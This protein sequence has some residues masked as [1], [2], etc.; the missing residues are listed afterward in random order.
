MS[1]SHLVWFVT[2]GAGALSLC[3]LSAVV[4]LGLVGAVGGQHPRWPRFLTTTLHRNLALLS[5][6]SLG[7]HIVTAVLDPFTALGW[8]AALVPWGSS[9]RTLWVGLGVISLYLGAAV[10]VTSLLRQWLS[11]Q[12]WRLVHWIAYAVWPLALIHSLG[13]G[14]D[15]RFLWMDTLYTVCCVAVAVFFVIRLARRKTNE[16]EPL[17]QAPA[18]APRWTRLDGGRHWR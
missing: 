1:G 15:T 6:V 11:Y 10:V 12:F 17:P 9:Y 5:L 3:L 18:G 13:A 8:G 2:R 4:V 7:I 14:S 16:P